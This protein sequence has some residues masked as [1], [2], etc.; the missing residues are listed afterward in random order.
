MS[1]VP[2]QEKLGWGNGNVED[3]NFAAGY[4][5]DG[6]VESQVL[7]CEFFS[8]HLFYFTYSWVMLRL[9]VLSQIITDMFSVVVW[10]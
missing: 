6:S 2:S 4:H 3:I 9:V 5:R 8:R 7:E 10:F 1:F